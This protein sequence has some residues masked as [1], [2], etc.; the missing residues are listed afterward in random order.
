MSEQTTPFDWR[1]AG[2]PLTLELTTGVFVPSTISRE[3]AAA[4]DVKPGSVGI[5]MGCGCGFLSFVAA[6][7]GAGMVYGSDSSAEAVRVATDNAVRLGMDDLTEFRVGNLFDALR[8]IEADFVIGDVSGIPDELARVSRWFP[9]GTGGGPTGAE[10]PIA[11]LE[12]MG[13]CLKPGGV[14]YLPTGSVQDEERILEVARAMFGPENVELVKERMIP[15]PPDVVQA[16]EVVDLISRGVVRVTER[17]SRYLWT[18]ATYR[19]TRT[20]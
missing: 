15:L 10:L 5:D 9:D 16:P 1:G 18:Y 7:L 4:L 8:D 2:G 6:R 13:S 19:C 12:D 11:M 14:L 20:Y 3:L 17:N